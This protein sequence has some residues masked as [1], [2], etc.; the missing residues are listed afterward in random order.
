MRDEESSLQLQHTLSTIELHK[1]N[2]RTTP[3]IQQQQQQPTTTSSLIVFRHLMKRSLRTNNKTTT[4]PFISSSLVI[5][6]SQLSSSLS[7]MIIALQSSRKEYMR[8]RVATEQIGDDWNASGAAAASP[9]SRSPRVWTNTSLP[10]CASFM[11]R[12]A[13]E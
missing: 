7:S 8:C 1:H 5:S 11:A 10:F 9:S 3:L 6:S 4:P 13:Q 12:L 2:T